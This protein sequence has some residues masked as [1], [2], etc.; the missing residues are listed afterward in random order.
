MDTQTSPPGNQ[1]S[2]NSVPPQ[3][4]ASDKGTGMAIL[5]YLGIL[6]IIPFLTEAHKNPYVK[7]HIKQGLVLII[8]WVVIGLIQ[9]VPFAF[10]LWFV[11]LILMIMGVINAASGKEK[12]LPLIGK[13]AHHFN[14]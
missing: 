13:F 1:G 8:A 5:A 12:E 2:A 6:I 7:F 10:V 11:L 14:F 9:M 4:P 3:Q